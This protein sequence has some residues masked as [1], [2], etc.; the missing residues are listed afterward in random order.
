[1]SSSFFE[2][3]KSQWLSRVLM[4]LGIL[5]VAL[6]IFQAGM[7]VG[8]RRAAISYH[9]GEDYYRAIG[10]HRGGPFAGPGEEFPN[11]NGAT[12]RIVNVQLPIIVIADQDNIEKTVI[13]SDRTTIRQFR[14][15]LS[16]SDLNINDF[17]V[18]IGSPNTTSQIEATL[19]RLLPPPP[20]PGSAAPTN[21]QPPIQ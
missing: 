9:W 8:Y 16:P 15:S 12:G 5:I 19:I 3:L 10:D 4:A 20:T 21:S 6:V 17:V 11:A 1:M 13:I 7:F 2:L 14:N 18:V